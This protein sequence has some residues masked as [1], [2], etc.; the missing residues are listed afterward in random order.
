MSR[1]KSQHAI[2]GNASE[3]GQESTKEKNMV[4]SRELFEELLE[5]CKDSLERMNK[6]HKDPKNPW[7]F[8]E[9]IFLL[10]QAI[11]KAEKGAK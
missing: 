8:K 2:V 5:A 9:Q 4:I 6:L 10:E 7:S 3:T 1:Q 11:A